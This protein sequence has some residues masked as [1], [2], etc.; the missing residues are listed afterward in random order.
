M[1]DKRNMT[2]NDL[3]NQ[4]N[5]LIGLLKAERNEDGF[6]SGR[7]ASSALATAVAI[8]ALKINQEKSDNQHI[9]SGLNWLLN[10]INN[11]GGYG[12]T[13]E[14]NSN[15]S[16]SLLCFAAI[17]YCGK[18]NDSAQKTIQNIENYLIQQKIDLSKKDVAAAV[19][20]FYGK[21]YTF[22]VPI[23]SM[24]VICGVI[25][26]KVCTKIPQLPFELTLFPSKWYSLFN[27]HVVSYAIP[28]LIAVGLFIFKKRIRHNPVMKL[29]RNRSIQ[30]ALR[31]LEKIVPESGGFLE[32]IPLTAFVDM[33]LISSGNGN[34]PVVSKGLGFIRN[35]HRADGSWPI[36]TDLSS[37]V[38]TLSIKAIGPDLPNVFDE[39]GLNK[40]KNH[41]HQ[42]QYKEVHPFNLA[43]PGGWGWTNFSGSVPDVDDTAG[44]IIALLDLYKT[45]KEE[46]KSIIDGS[47]W[48]TSLQNKDGG[49]PTFCRGWGRLPFDSSCADLT[50]HALLALTRSLEV[51]G[52]QMSADLQ[53][54]VNICIARAFGFLWKDQ[55]DNGSW[56][57]L[58][59]GNQHAAGQKNPVYGTAKVAIYLKDCL[60]QNC[61]DTN[62][63]NNMRRML[64]YARNYLL[65]Q[66][67]ENGGWGGESGLQSTIEESSLAISALAD[68]NREAILK[69]FEWLEYEFNNNGLRS[70]P[71][72]LY[73][74]MLWYDEQL[75]PLIYYVEALRRFLKSEIKS[76]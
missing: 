51:L 48:L 60:A 43:Q 39:P 34:N 25:D 29:L 44:A 42:I 19:L 75:Y 70:S 8:V 16:T 61:L 59:F 15:V 62:M 73:F 14:S 64:E 56:N 58:W 40:L 12:D 45:G 18:E 31:K 46:E 71:I 22:S 35:Q 65:K 26:K 9:M 41:L 57:P 21:D 20:A 54:S 74:A 50:G 17:S 53:K 7:L 23:L 63:K 4:Y 52:S 2:Q 47:R 49:F 10:N 36:D 37:W 1:L 67:N 11:D 55:H 3:Q 30:P 66:Q 28:A 24:L 72:G 5:H 76:L 6:W 32:A 33:C 38:T 27:L 68:D 13:P 69:G